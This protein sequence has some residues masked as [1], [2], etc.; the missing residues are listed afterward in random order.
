MSYMYD[1]HVYVYVCVCIVHIV[2]MGLFSLFTVGQV[3]NMATYK[4][5]GKAGVYYGFLLGKSTPWYSG[6]PF[7]VIRF[8]SPCFARCV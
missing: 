8:A 2:Y 6:F 7:T 3:L 4:A 5:L 1:I